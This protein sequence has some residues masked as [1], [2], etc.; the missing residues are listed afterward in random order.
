[1]VGYSVRFTEKRIFN[2]WLPWS[3]PVYTREFTA[4]LYNLDPNNIKIFD[5]CLDLLNVKYIL[6]FSGIRSVYSDQIDTLTDIFNSSSY[7]KFIGN[8]SSSMDFTIIYE[9]KGYL[10]KYLIVKNG[11]L[12]DNNNVFFN[13]LNDL[14]NFQNDTYRFFSNNALFIGKYQEDLFIQNITD[15]EYSTNTANFSIIE[16]KSNQVK[17]KVNVTEDCFFIFSQ[18]WFPN[19]KAYINGNKTDIFRSNYLFMGVSISKGVS[20][21]TFRYEDPWYYKT[22]ILIAILAIFYAIFMFK[23][24]SILKLFRRLVN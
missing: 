4:Y 11:I 15:L 13:V 20:E 2:Y 24:P 9:N 3:A 21:I 19:W 12:L 7:F 22:S 1:M 23:K 16:E 10:P 8:Y 18:S 5:L 14:P 6:L 17:F